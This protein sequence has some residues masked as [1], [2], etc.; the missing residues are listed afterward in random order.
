MVVSVKGIQV[1]MV[2][3]MVVNERVT[4]ILLVKRVSFFTR[5][6][7]KVHVSVNSVEFEGLLLEDDKTQKV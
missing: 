7:I 6:V 2:N 5:T 3:G 4:K 1:S